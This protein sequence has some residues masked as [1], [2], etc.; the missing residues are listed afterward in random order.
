MLESVLLMNVLGNRISCEG[1]H[2]YYRG[3]TRSG[4]RHGDQRDRQLHLLPQ[5]QYV[6]VRI[7]KIQK[8]VQF[9]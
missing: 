2:E 8:S 6:V 5:R 1:R 7:F 9:L 3:L 4:G